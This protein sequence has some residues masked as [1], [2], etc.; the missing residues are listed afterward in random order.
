MGKRII[1][2]K[3]NRRACVPGRAQLT[4]PTGVE[5]L[6]DGGG[7]FSCAPMTRTALAQSFYPEQS[8]PVAGFI[9]AGIINHYPML[10]AELTAAGWRSGVR[11]YSA[12]QV[13][14]LHRFMAD[15]PSLR[16]IECVEMY[17]PAK[18]KKKLM[19]KM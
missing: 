1:N 12:R 8:A 18:F 2:N 19:N 13:E 4:L 14:I 10:K 15:H 7:G 9:M 17:V 5:R 3:R 11:G 16:R 6:C